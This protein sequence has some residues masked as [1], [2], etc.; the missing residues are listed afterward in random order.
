MG[1]NKNWSNKE[2]DLLKHNWEKKPKNQI[3]KLFPNRSYRAIKFKANRLGFKKKVIFKI[4]KINMTPTKKAYLAGF[5]DGEGCI[6]AHFQTEEHRKRPRIGLTIV[7]TNKT[8]IEQIAKDLNCSIFS[9]LPNDYSG[10]KR[11]FKRC[12]RIRIMN[13]SILLPFLK[14]IKLYSIVKKKQIEL[15]IKLMKIRGNTYRGATSSKEEVELVK[16]VQSLNH[17]GE[18]K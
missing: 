2:L 6:S 9:Y 17:K 7:N 3:I 15:A 1:S 18:I 5:I 14:A 13:L 12:Y 8:V 10:K 16:K 11:H 4:K